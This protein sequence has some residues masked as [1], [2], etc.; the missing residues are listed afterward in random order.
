MPELP[1]LTPDQVAALV[2]T[3]SGIEGIGR[4]G[5]KLVFRGTVAGTA[6]AFK[7]ARVPTSEFDDAEDISATDVV[8][9][10]RREV[11]TMQQCASPYFVKLGPEGL[12]VAD[13]GDQTVVYFSEELIEGRDLSDWLQRGERFSSVDT[14]LL[15]RQIAEAIKA[16]WE[17]KKIHRDIKPQNIMRRENSGDFVLLDAGFAFDISGESLSYGPVGT[18]L[19]FSPEQFEFTNRR[20]VLDFRSD[21]FSLGVTM[22]QV[23]TGKHPFWESGDTSA[24]LCSKICNYIP[25]RPSVL[26]PDIPSRLDEV[27]QRMLAKS[28]HLRY[29]TCDR[30]IAALQGL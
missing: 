30:L 16:L 10:A 3:A 23:A 14:A 5:Q 17:H 15:G 6:Y 7:F 2:P 26:A 13:I 9:R 27:I 25:Q 1:S 8:R 4:G 12:Q 18:P 22:Y 24:D 11:E 29:R 21:M 28:P 19:Y 20:T